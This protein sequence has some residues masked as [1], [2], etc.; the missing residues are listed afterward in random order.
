MSA[1]K[2]SSIDNSPTKQ[3]YSFGRAERFPKISTYG[4]MSIYNL[5]KVNNTRA[6][7]FGYGNRYSFTPRRENIT[8]SAYDYS[9]GVESTQ[10]YTP[11][12]SFGVSRE[13]MKDSYDRNVPGPGKYYCTLKTFGKDGAKYSIKGKYGC[14][15][16]KIVLSPGPAAYDPATKIN[17]TGVFGVSKFKN[18]QSVDFSR[19]DEERF[20][21]NRENSPGPAAYKNDNNMFGNI[22]NSRYK[23]THGIHLGSRYKPYSFDINNNPGPGTYE[24][25]GDFSR[26]GDWSYKGSKRSSNRNSRKNSLDNQNTNNQKSEEEKEKNEESKENN[27]ND[28]N[29]ENKESENDDKKDDDAKENEEN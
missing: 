17:P 21:S 6:T 22:Y 19:G 8:P 16:D 12:Y 3:R 5:P 25:Y 18:V 1:K 7:S 24:S 28:E 9:Y 2:Y 10:P 14:L 11:K 27:E 26:Y 20:K 13:N 4:A 23:S 29:K 15:F